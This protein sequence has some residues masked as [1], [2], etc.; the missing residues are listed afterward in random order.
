MVTAPERSWEQSVQNALLPHGTKI[1]I[2]GFSHFTSSPCKDAAFES[3]LNWVSALHREGQRGGVRSSASTP[4]R[5]RVAQPR[6]RREDVGAAANGE[7]CRIAE[8]AHELRVE[9]AVR[10]AEAA[11]KRTRCEGGRPKRTT[12][13]RAC[14]RLAPSC[15][16]QPLRGLMYAGAN[17]VLP[18]QVF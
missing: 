11:I 4:A 5:E 12:M 9:D 2:F 8:T 7:S 14:L 1:R 6:A 10:D 13:Q 15:S 17:A 16:P 18:R 3:V